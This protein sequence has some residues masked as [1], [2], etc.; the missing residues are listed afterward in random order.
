MIMHTKII[1]TLAIFCILSA[2]LSSCLK[3]NLPPY[4]LATGDYITNIYFQYRYLDSNA[5]EWGQPTVA[6]ENLILQDQIDTPNHTIYCQLTVPSPSGDFDQYQWNQVTLDSIWAVTEISYAATV[7]PV[8]NAPAF[9]Y[10]GNYSIPQQYKVQAAFP[11]SVQIWT[12]NVT[13]FTKT[14]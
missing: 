14:P 8:G 2:C 13:S 10:Q 1:R 3:H 11:D 12:I 7:T 6:I 4:P 9:S 5:M